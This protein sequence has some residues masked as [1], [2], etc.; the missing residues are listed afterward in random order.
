MRRI[1]VLMAAVLAAVTLGAATAAGETTTGTGTASFYID[2][3]ACPGLVTEQPYFHPFGSTI[4]ATG[5]YRITY[6]RDET[7]PTY[8]V[9]STIRGT[10]TDVNTGDAYT[11]TFSG[12]DTDVITDLVGTGVL[13]FR[14]IGGG[15]MIV[16]GAS[17]IITNWIFVSPENVRCVGPGS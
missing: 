3:S 6:R 7:K 4:T 2:T 5:T 13:V 12:R 9:W 8:D 11:W 14:K 17:L 16:H 10:A 1:S 15:A